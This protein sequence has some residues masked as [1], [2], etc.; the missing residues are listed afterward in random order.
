MLVAA[1]PLYVIHGTLPSLKDPATLAPYVT[2]N[3]INMRTGVMHPGL[4][5]ASRGG[6]I[7][8]RPAR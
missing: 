3:N 8:M 2:R 1:T 6:S 4:I 5:Q 7:L